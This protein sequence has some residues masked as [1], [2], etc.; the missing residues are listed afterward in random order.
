MS[1]GGLICE[2]NGIIEEPVQENDK[3]GGGF[4]MWQVADVFKQLKVRVGDVVCQDF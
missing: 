3:P 1:R 4:N 2:C